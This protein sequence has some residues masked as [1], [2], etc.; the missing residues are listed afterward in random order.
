MADLRWI[1]VLD[2]N[3]VVSALLSPLGPPAQILGLTLAGELTAA[4]DSRILLEYRDVLWRREFGFSRQRVANVL[5]ALEGD[6]LSVAA[7]PLAGRLADRA[8]EPFLEVAAAAGAPLITG[9]LR[10]FPPSRRG[11]VAVLSPR[12]FLESLRRS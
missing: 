1:V 7:G 4:Y 11:G 5:E 12:E 10:H 8:D 3:V 9:N 2:T 6:G